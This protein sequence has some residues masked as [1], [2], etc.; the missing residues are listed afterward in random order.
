MKIN[1][2]PFGKPEVLHFISPY[3]LKEYNNRWYIL[4]KSNHFEHFTC[5]ALDLIEQIEEA[6]HYEYLPYPA[7]DKPEDFFEDFIGVT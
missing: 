7:G 1:Y 6:G 2:K 4:C 3:L 5:L